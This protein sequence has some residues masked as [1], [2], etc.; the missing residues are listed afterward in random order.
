M[1]SLQEY[2]KYEREL[3]IRHRRVDLI[4]EILEKG[5]M[6]MARNQTS[7]LVGNSVEKEKR[8]IFLNKFLISLTYLEELSLASF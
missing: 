5:S 3:K 2:K 4:E 1:K 6:E 8:R 7:Q